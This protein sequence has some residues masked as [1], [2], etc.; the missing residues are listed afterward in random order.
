MNS[1]LPL[2]W[3]QVA[4]LLLLA[5]LSYVECVPDFETFLFP[6][7]FLLTLWGMLRHRR[8]LPLT[9]IE[10]IARLMAPLTARVRLL[11]IRLMRGKTLPLKHEEPSTCLCC[12]EEYT[13]NFCPRCG[14]SRKTTRYRL[15]NALQ[16]IA[17]GFFNIDTGFGRTML[18]LLHR[19]GYMIRDFI[20]GQRAPQFRPF[21]MLF[22]LAAL[23]I[24]IVQLVDPEALLRTQKEDDTAT[25]TRWE[26]VKK[27]LEKELETE[28]D[29]ATI[30]IAL[31]EINSID[32]HLQA[33]RKEKA[34]SEPIVNDEAEEDYGI[35]ESLIEGGDLV[36]NNADAT[37]AD[38]SYLQR[39]CKLLESWMHGNKAFRIIAT[40]PLFALATLF[41]FRR[42]FSP[43][44]NLTEHLFIQAYIACQTLLISILVLPFCGQAQVDDLYD[45]P[46]WLIFFL[47]WIDYKQLYHASWW[48]SFWGTARML[49]YSLLILV[50]L[51]ALIIGILLLLGS[52]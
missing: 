24:M 41:S 20:A 36:R 16:N 4:I 28:Q 50:A 29:S 15:R 8:I 2:C 11:N 9:W 46:Q 3:W 30:A 21:Q 42:R 27:E 37:L 44:Y 34:T 1:R 6:T 22:I 7:I 26:E 33:V 39:V 45:V 51:A 35:I 17:S 18:D 32:R 38:S 10:T 43:R 25:Q 52:A 19:P 47:F 14:Q 31:Q 40:L 48:G 13:G 23:Y 49:I 5:C 12:G